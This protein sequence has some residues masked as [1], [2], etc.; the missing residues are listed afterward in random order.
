[1]RTLNLQLRILR[2]DVLA[3]VYRSDEV[4]GTNAGLSLAD[5][6]EIVQGG[7]LFWLTMPWLLRRHSFQ[8]RQG[9]LTLTENGRRRAQSLVRSHRLWEAYLQQHFEMP[10]DHLHYAASRAEHYIGPRLQ[11]ELAAELATP[12]RD[13]HGRE[14]PPAQGK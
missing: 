1:M 7:R 14:I 13:P 2:Q 6:A 11:E 8:M 5:C 9:R 3:A 4:H 10:L 12:P